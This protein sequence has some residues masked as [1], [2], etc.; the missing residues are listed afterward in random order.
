MH[1]FMFD[2]F[3]PAIAARVRV[4]HIA[5]KSINRPILKKSRHYGFG[6]FIVHSSM[7]SPMQCHKALLVYCVSY[8]CTVYIHPG[9]TRPS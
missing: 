7:G 2:S 6:V 3:F 1:E 9:Q 4:K 5:A 8:I